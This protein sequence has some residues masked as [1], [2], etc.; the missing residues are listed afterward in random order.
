MFVAPDWIVRI[1]AVLRADMP[2][3]IVEVGNATTRPAGRQ[4][5]STFGPVLKVHN[6]PARRQQAV[7]NTRCEARCT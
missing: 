6:P 4:R 2:K 1:F 5:V 3:I 7:L